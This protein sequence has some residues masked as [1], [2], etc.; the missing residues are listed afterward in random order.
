MGVV[1]PLFVPREYTPADPDSLMSIPNGVVKGGIPSGPLAVRPKHLDVFT[2]VKKRHLFI[3]V[4]SWDYIARLWFSSYNSARNLLRLLALIV[5]YS[6]RLPSQISL[7]VH[8]H[9]VLS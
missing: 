5:F 3:R 1:I 2:G 6:T 8:T 7:A 9:T 4:F